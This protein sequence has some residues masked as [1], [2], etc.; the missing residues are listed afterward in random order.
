MHARHRH[1][2]RLTQRLGERGQRA[3]LRVHEGQPGAIERVLFDR[4]EI[5]TPAALRIVAPG[6]PGGQEV[7]A[8]PEA[9]LHDGEAA[10]ALPPAGQA[11]AAQEHVM[12]LRQAAFG[13]VVD[14]VVPGGEQRAVRGQLRCG[15]NEA[16]RHGQSVREA[17]DCIALPRGLGLIRRNG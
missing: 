14:V 16:A 13:A 11:V 4:N 5:E 12:R 9:G 3:L 8:L 7:Q 1:R 2:P 10:L 17:P 6:R 15:E